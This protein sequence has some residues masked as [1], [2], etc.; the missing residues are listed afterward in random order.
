MWVGIVMA[1]LEGIELFLEYF[2]YSSCLLFLTVKLFC[3]ELFITQN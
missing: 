1:W 2:V 3:V